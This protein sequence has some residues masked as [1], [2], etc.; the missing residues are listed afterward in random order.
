[1]R[2]RLIIVGG[3]SRH[4]GKTSLVVALLRTLHA[5]EWTAVKI[6]SHR[7]GMASE[8]VEENPAESRYLQAGAGR[9][10]LVCAPDAT[11]ERAVQPIRRM[12]AE[13]RNVIVE[14]NRFAAYC[15]AD[16][17]LFVIAPSIA[18]WKP[19]SMHPLRTADAIV[20]SGEGELPPG[21]EALAGERIRG[22]PLFR[23]GEPPLEICR[24]WVQFCRRAAG[25]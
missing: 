24:E 19:S 6:S 2:G 8:W 4:V 7:H 16:L 9:A 14:S 20:L 1:M 3:H 12:L 13:G 17:T 5:P 22:L 25:S 10:F 11:F 23:L 15:A 18:D 21:A